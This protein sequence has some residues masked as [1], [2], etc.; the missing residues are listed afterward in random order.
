VKNPTPYYVSFTEINAVVNQKRVPL[1]PNGD[2]LAPGQEKHC[3]SP[4]TS[5]VLLILLT[6]PLM[7]LADACP[8][9]RISKSNSWNRVSGPEQFISESGL[10]LVKECFI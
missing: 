9:L 7:I 10:N 3:P 8:V 1:A 5:R 2:M 4:V 6:P